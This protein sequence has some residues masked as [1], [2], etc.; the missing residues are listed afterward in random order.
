MF[1]KLWFCTLFSAHVQSFSTFNGKYLSGHSFLTLENMGMRMCARDCE[2]YGGGCKSVNFDRDHFVCELNSKNA[3]DNPNDLVDKSSSVHIQVNQSSI[4]GTCGSKTCSTWDKCIVTHSGPECLLMGCDIPKIKN[5]VFNSGFLPFGKSLQC[6]TGYQSLITWTCADKNK[7]P[8]DFKCYKVSSG[9]V[10]IYRSQAGG[11]VSDYLS[12]ISNGTSDETNDDIIDEHCTAT[13]KS[14]LC[15]SKYRTSLIDQW[16]SLDISQVQ[17]HLYK[18]GTQVAEV[19]FNG[20][21]STNTDWFSKNRVVSSTWTDVTP[22]QTYNYFS[23]EGHVLESNY[24]R[25]FQIWNQ[26]GGCPNDVFWMTSSF[27]KPGYACPQE[28]NSTI[29]YFYCPQTTKCNFENNYELA[30]VMTISIQVPGVT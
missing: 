13:T 2:A 21:G 7:D 5:A 14:A 1:H 18:S 20:T 29:Q 3:T 19:V 9:W 26:Y 12:F 28:R 16:E 23:I 30:D 24:W 17:L 11:N 27:A 6:Q 15:T 25:N 8:T 4:T 22:T 10:L